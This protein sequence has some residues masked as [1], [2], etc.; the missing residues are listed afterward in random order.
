M[1]QTRRRSAAAAPLAAAAPTATTPGG[2]VGARAGART[3]C[4]AAR[5]ACAVL[6]GNTPSVG[7]TGERSHER[8]RNSLD[9][10]DRSRAGVVT[11]RRAGSTSARRVAVWGAVADAS[12]GISVVTGRYS[13]TGV[14][15]TEPGGGTGAGLL[16]PA[17]LKLSGEAATAD[18]STTDDPRGVAVDDAIGLAGASFVD[19]ATPVTAST[20]PTGLA[21]VDRTPLTGAVSGAAVVFS[22]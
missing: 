6:P 15:D 10:A 14:P 11:G 19:A 13:E 7:S 5:S 16:P 17:R 4:G 3:R 9:G 18:G 21:A 20:S 2:A 8:G 22:T 12:G 1:R